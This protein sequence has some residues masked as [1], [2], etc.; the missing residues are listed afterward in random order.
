MDLCQG[1]RPGS[2]CRWTKSGLKA[3]PGFVEIKTQ[4][5]PSVQCAL[6]ILV[7][8]GDVKIHI[9]LGLGLEEL[10]AVINGLGGTS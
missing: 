4:A 9:P 7:E 8:K 3:K 10:R 6:E 5:I 2:F 1:K